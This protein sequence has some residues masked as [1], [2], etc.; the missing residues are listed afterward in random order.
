MR[1]SSSRR[2]TSGSASRAAGLLRS[3][4][5]RVQTLSSL[6][7]S[8]SL[9][10]R[11][12]MVAP[13]LPFPTGTLANHRSAGASHQSTGPSAVLTSRQ[14][15]VSIAAEYIKWLEK[16][17]SHAQ[18]PTS[19]TG[20]HAAPVHRPASSTSTLR[21]AGLRRKEGMMFKLERRSRSR[22]LV[23]GA[24][25]ASVAVLAYASAL[26]VGT[27][28][29]GAST[30]KGTAGSTL[31]WALQ[32]NPASLFDAYYFSTEGSTMFSLVQDH[33]LTPG[34]FGQP[35]TGEGSVTASWKALNPTT[36]TY[37]IKR[38]IRFSNGA[39]LTAKDVAFSMRV[40]MD[41]ATG[42][43]MHDFFGNVRSVTT[44]GN[45]VTVRLLKPD[46]NWQYTPAASPGLVYSEADYKAK[47]ASFGTPSGL[48]IGTGPYKFSQFV[49]NSKVVLTR[50]PYYKG[51]KYPWD[52]IVFQVIPDE[53]ARLLALQSG[54]VDG[55]FQVPNNSL[56]TWMKAPNVKVGT[57]LS[58]G[59]R[60]FSFDVEDGPFSDV[61]VRR[62]LAYSL[63]KVGIT[64]ALTS[65]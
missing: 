27:G 52:Q 10:T 18:T 49:P 8:V 54:Q 21:P 36:Y 62:A 6:R 30:A 47:G 11:P 20:L 64:Y 61:H 23:R 44:R 40:H 60:G 13:S 5:Q 45:T 16:S 58:G 2:R 56:N 63:D 41:K 43:K 19:R 55:T 37:T 3:V 31:T 12:R 38:G 42:S 57:Y 22:C 51:K 48:P 65:G 33:I 26:V 9:K 1:P 28:N 7:I 39:P 24:V 34:T 15:G 25:A 53:Q 17:F 59:W 35:Q 32:T 46:S 14:A 4:G 50:N 29:S